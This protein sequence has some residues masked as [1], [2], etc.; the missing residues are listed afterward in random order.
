MTDTIELTEELYPYYHNRG[1]VPCNKVAFYSTV[2]IKDGMPLRASQVIYPDGSKPFCGDRAKC[3]SC[4]YMLDILDAGG[5][6]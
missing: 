4:G 2:P 5:C 1:P 3:G 6:G